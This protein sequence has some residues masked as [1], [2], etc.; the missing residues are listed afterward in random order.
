VDCETEVLKNVSSNARAMSRVA[1]VT[2]LLIV[3]KVLGLYAQGIREIDTSAIRSYFIA[4]EFSF[5]L[6]RSSEVFPA[7]MV[8]VVL[9]VFSLFFGVYY[10]KIFLENPKTV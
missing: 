3:Y 5:D 10:K 8:G 6:L 9:I 2:F 1:T 7:V 4:F